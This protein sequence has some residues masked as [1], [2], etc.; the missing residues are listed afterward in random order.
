MVDPLIAS[1]S[2][3]PPASAVERQNH[4]CNGYATL[5]N[6][7]SSSVSVTL[8]A[9]GGSAQDVTFPGIKRHLLLYTTSLVPVNIMAPRDDACWVL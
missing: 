4:H 7:V 6:R 5:L 9:H 8:K 3:P 1:D 2:I